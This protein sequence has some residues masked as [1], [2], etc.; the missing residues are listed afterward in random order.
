M[1]AK[2]FELGKLVGLEESEIDQAKRTTKTVIRTCIIAGV[3]ALIG[4]FTISR[5][6]AVGLWYIPPSIKDFSFFSRLF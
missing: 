2:L 1:R 6:E 4:I 3:I 5:L